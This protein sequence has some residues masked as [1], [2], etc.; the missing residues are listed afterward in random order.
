MR[1][2]PR[3]PASSR[4]VLPVSGL[5]VPATGL[6]LLAAGLASG[7]DADPAR[8]GDGL[9]PVS[10]SFAMTAPGSDVPA[11]SLLRLTMD[12][13][14]LERADRIACRDEDDCALLTPDTIR[15]VFTTPGDRTTPLAAA[16]PEGRFDALVVRVRIVHVVGIADGH[17]FDRLVALWTDLRL[18]FERT[19]FLDAPRS[20]AVGLTVFARPDLLFVDSDG[21]RIDPRTAQTAALAELL[22]ESLPRALRVVRDDDP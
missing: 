14:R 19:L 12:S 13:V 2:R 21:R 6:V 5:A 15:A 4:R 18:P 20:E 1:S 3:N 22:T 9:V 8:P 7:C 16:A 17:G 10:V 11:V